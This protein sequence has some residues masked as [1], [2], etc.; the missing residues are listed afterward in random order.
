MARL[1]LKQLSNELSE[2]NAL[3]DE[4]TWAGYKVFDVLIRK[5]VRFLEILKD[6][7]Y[8]KGIDAWWLDATEP[9]FRDGFTQ[10][11][12][13]ERTKS[14]GRNYLGTFHRY[15]NTYSLNY[16]NFYMR[17]SNKRSGKRVFILT[18]SAFASQQQ[19]ATAVWSVMYRFLG[20]YA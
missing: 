7:L 15:L 18:R 13:E 16:P 19:Y 11:K 6:G 3:F 20:K 8:D 14:A 2:I 5:L 9:S 1:V 17:N 4:R 12:Q 10:L